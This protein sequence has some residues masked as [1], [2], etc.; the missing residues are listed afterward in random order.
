MVNIFS[1]ASVVIGLAGF[2]GSNSAPRDAAATVLLI[3]GVLAYAATA[4]IAFE[5]L[6]PRRWH[7][8]LNVDEWWRLLW[9]RTEEEA[10]HSILSDLAQNYALNKPLLE[11]KARTI[12]LALVTTSVEVVL[13]GLALISL[14]AS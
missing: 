13:V 10:R 5:H 12:R 14:Q 1:A 2:S 11:S 6:Q 8:S 3:M 4:Y 7:R 9:Y